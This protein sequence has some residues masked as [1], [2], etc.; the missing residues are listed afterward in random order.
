MYVRRGQTAKWLLTEC[1]KQSA[2]AL[3]E[4]LGN[5]SLCFQPR[6]AGGVF[7]AFLVWTLV[8]NLLTLMQS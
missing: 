8:E 1:G 3:K 7:F 5:V 6:D 4:E 2:Q